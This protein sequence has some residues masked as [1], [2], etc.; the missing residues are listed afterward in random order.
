VLND[1]E[2]VGICVKNGRIRDDEDAVVW[3]M[4]FDVHDDEVEVKN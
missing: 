3:N 2:F 1:F 4:I